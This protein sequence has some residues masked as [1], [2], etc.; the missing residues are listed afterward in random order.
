MMSPKPIQ[1]IEVIFYALL[2]I[3][4]SDPTSG[5]MICNIKINQQSIGF[6]KQEE[7]LKLLENEP[8]YQFISQKFKEANDLRIQYIRD[9]IINNIKTDLEKYQNDK[10]YLKA[11]SKLAQYTEDLFII[12]GTDKY[13]YVSGY[14]N[15]Q[16]DNRIL[17]KYNLRRI[18]AKDF[19][20]P[21]I[22]QA[23]TQDIDSFLADINRFDMKKIQSEIDSIVK[24]QTIQIQ[25]SLKRRILYDIQINEQLLRLEDYINKQEQNLQQFLNTIELFGMKNRIENNDRIYDLSGNIRIIERVS[26]KNKKI[27]FHFM[28]IQNITYLD[29]EDLGVLTQ[30]MKQ[31]IQQQE[32]RKYVDGNRIQQQEQFQQPQNQTEGQINRKGQIKLLPQQTYQQQDQQIQ[33]QDIFDNRQRT[34]IKNLIIVQKN[35]GQTN[36]QNQN[37][38]QQDRFQSKK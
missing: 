13:F 19:L 18:Q 34:P 4:F 3:G 31:L 8:E 10:H 25:Q 33:R 24:N 29:F 11:Q 16:N 5:S 20:D 37:Q 7:L 38:N 21:Q 26:K 32:Q 27:L 2:S 35:Q 15:S 17:D 28:Q 9:Q 12:Q 23:F 36:S 22:N 1:E 6:I 30:H 14:L